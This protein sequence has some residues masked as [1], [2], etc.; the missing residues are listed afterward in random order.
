M[1]E[2][3]KEK[4]EK[5]QEYLSETVIVLSHKG[6]YFG[7]LVDAEVY[8]VAID[9]PQ[10]VCHWGEKNSPDVIS[11]DYP[12]IDW[13][14]D[15]HS[16]MIFSEKIRMSMEVD[17]LMKNLAQY[18]PGRDKMILTPP[19]WGD[20]YVDEIIDIYKCTDEAAVAVRG[21]PQESLDHLH[22]LVQMINEEGKPSLS[23]GLPRVGEIRRNWRDYFRRFSAEEIFRRKNRKGEE[24]GS[25]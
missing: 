11:E 24:I 15:I 9:S 8:A 5:Y 16:K 17:V 22:S 4:L 7:Q 3:Y 6:I 23:L 25:W 21:L 18:G 2:E 19:A 14:M 12:V 20:V 13:E 1:R 10:W